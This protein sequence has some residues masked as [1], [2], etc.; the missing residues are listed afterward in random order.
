MSLQLRHHFSKLGKQGNLPASLIDAEILIELRRIGAVAQL[1]ASRHRPSAKLFEASTDTF[2]SLKATLPSRFEKDLW[3]ETGI[4]TEELSSS[5]TVLSRKKQPYTL[6]SCRGVVFALE[7]ALGVKASC[8]WTES[9]SHD[10][11]ARRLP[12]VL[13][14]SAALAVLVHLM[15]FSSPPHRKLAGN[16]TKLQLSESNQSPY[17]PQTPLGLTLRKKYNGMADLK[18]T[19]ASLQRFKPLLV[20][21]DIWSRPLSALF[22]DG[23]RHWAISCDVQ[24]PWPSQAVILDALTPLECGS[25]IVEWEGTYSLRR[26]DGH[27]VGVAAPLRARFA[28]Q[29]LLG[30]VCGSIGQMMPGY[31]DDPIAGKQYGLATPLASDVLLREILSDLQ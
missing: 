7:E 8:P 3:V 6:A 5:G 12:L 31:V 20:R 1:S 4:I 27:T 15:E 10:E 11:K 30:R 23:L 19:V 26:G 18:R 21:H 29:T 28:A 22:Q 24:I 25:G 16:G 2:T 14:P 13:G 9:T 17:P